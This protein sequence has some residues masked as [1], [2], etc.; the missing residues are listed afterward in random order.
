L[1]QFVFFPDISSSIVMYKYSESN[2]ERTQT[3]ID[4]ESEISLLF[5][6][7]KVIDAPESPE[8]NNSW[9][10]AGVQVIIIFFIFFFIYLTYQP[11]S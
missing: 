5:P 1:E 2:Q 6:T 8:E 4:D 3:R 9:W 11:I 10:F 7:S